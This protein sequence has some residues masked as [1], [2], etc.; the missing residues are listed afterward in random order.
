MRFQL[1]TVVNACTLHIRGSHAGYLKEWEPWIDKIPLHAPLPAQ[2]KSFP[3]QTEAS[4]AH[5]VVQLPHAVAQ[6]RT[7]LGNLDCML[8]PGY[9]KEIQQDLAA[10][11]CGPLNLC[12]RG[13]S[14][15]IAVQWACEFHT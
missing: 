15:W 7:S 11:A 12:N 13:V 1:P 14:C 2:Y 9:A 4:C 6:T 5:E 3:A 8:G 10:G